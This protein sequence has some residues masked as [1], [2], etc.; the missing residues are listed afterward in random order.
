MCRRS[1][2]LTNAVAA[3]LLIPALGACSANAPP[4]QAAAPTGATGDAPLASG[5]SNGAAERL[6]VAAASCWYGGL[7]ADA[8]GE[9]GDA[10]TKGIQDRC[11]DVLVR[12]YGS[13][14]RIHYE[15]LRGLEPRAVSD[16]VN[17]V[18]AIAAG[19]HLD[20]PRGR[21]LGELVRAVADAQRENVVAR[22]AADDVKKSEQGPSTA[23]ERAEDKIE[24]AKA[25]RRTKAIEALLTRDFGE[26]SHEA[27]AFGLLSALDRVTMARGLPKHL[28]VYAVSGPFVRLFGVTPV[29]VPDDATK[30]IKT[31]TWPAYL[32]DVSTAGGHPL[33]ADATI[34]I[35]RET[36][37]WVGVLEGFADKMR[38][39]AKAVS[40]RTPLRGVL[41]NV[42][43][44]LDGEYRMQRTLL[45]AE[46][47]RRK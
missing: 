7:W 24:A 18:T 16:V 4:R 27:R 40:P 31:G 47:R 35:D 41:E 5:E 28:K 44:R 6:A 22:A 10:R 23:S 39:E 32:I 17:R 21:A 38:P 20:A 13:V 19:D 3:L 33:P 36:Q 8:L 34:P 15:Q 9:S 1:K 25:L 37:A 46:H 43:A 14:D 42:I 30:P 26:L 45:E 2:T 11:D 12:V 29:E